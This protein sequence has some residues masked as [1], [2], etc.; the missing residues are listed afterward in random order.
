MHRILDQRDRLTTESAA[1][2]D[3][4]HEEIGKIDD[5]AAA[6]RP[7]LVA[8]RR[9]LYKQRIPAERA[10]NDAV[11][12]FLAAA[13]RER[14]I[15]FLDTLVRQQRMTAELEELLPAEQRA[16]TQ[17]LRAAV[18]D[19]NYRHALSLASPVLS[20]ELEKWLADPEL[21]LRPQTL[22]R[23]AEYLTR[24]ATRTS[25]YSTFTISGFG[26]WAPAGAAV[27]FLDPGDV[28]SVVD[29][30]GAVLGSV[31]ESLARDPLLMPEHLVRVNPSATMDSGTVS[32]LSGGSGEPIVSLP[33]TPTLAECLRIVRETAPCSLKALWGELERRS[34]RPPETIRTFLTKLSHA[35]LLEL[36]VPVPDQSTDPFGDIAEWLGEKTPDDSAGLVKSLARLR[37]EV[38]IPLDPADTG[39]GRRQRAAMRGA[40][41]DLGEQ[42]RPLWRSESI[43]DKVLFHENAVYTGTVAEVAVDAWRSALDDLDVLRRWLGLFDPALPLRIVLSELYHRRFEPG[44]RVPVLQLHRAVQEELAE[45][46]YLKDVDLQALLKPRWHALRSALAD[47][48]LPRIQEL[49][50][51]IDESV[52]MVTGDTAGGTVVRTDPQALREFVERLPSWIQEPES[53]TCYVQILAEG[54]GEGR[55]ERVGLRL[56]VNGAMTGH[57]RTRARLAAIGEQ[58]G[59]APLPAEMADEPGAEPGTEPL[60]AEIGAAFGSGLNVRRPSLPYEICYPGALS[61]RPSDRQLDIGDLVA[62]PDPADPADPTA[63]AAGL[64]HLYSQRLGKRVHPVHLG[65]VAEPFLPPVARLLAN[66]FGAHAVLVPG[67]SFLLPTESGA[68]EPGASQPEGVS[69]LPR[70]EVGRVTIRRAR[71][72]VAADDVP[73]PAKGETPGR[74][75]LRLAGWLRDEGIPPRGFVRALDPPSEGEG[76]VARWLLQ[77]GHKPVYVDFASALH[78]R[79]FTRMATGCRGVMVFEEPRPAP[80]DALR[81]EGESARV[82]EFAVEL[83][84]RNDGEGDRG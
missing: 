80:E 35:G 2:S 68:G 23:L 30:S 38:R 63:P 8:L 11:S 55:D 15:A 12:G 83:T 40:L 71:W 24:A 36:H 17:E 28:R 46:T 79:T 41:D 29:L 81:T 73:L 62:A 7:G 61:D 75:L 84:R 14:V 54:D 47:C 58:A 39:S 20:K 6:L 3:L 33:E 77:G 10:W 32:F 65:L 18:H 42:L 31:K 16:R 66:G 22:A 76:E 48:P 74:Y 44:S 37:G 34:G 78:V 57:G 5:G 1:L 49:G 43:P 72:V 52:A 59:A 25:P 70:L 53:M 21:R 82:T 4:L 67:V 27:R 60:L 45:P 9:D 56:V 50:R 69:F 26:S 19:E 51:L 13:T 64:L